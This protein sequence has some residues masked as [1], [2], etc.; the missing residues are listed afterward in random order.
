MPFWRL[1]L[2]L[3]LSIAV[4]SYGF[5]FVGRADAC[6]EPARVVGAEVSAT[7]DSCCDAMGGQ[8]H[9]SDD[10]CKRMCSIGGDC[11]SATLLQPAIDPTPAAV[12]QGPLNSWAT[13]QFV[14]A[15]PSGVWRP[16]RSL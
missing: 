10:A 16:P 12:S 9:D 15:D 4:P 2:V 3:L 5:G 7:M 6:P 1:I 8:G 13:A 11:R 14:A